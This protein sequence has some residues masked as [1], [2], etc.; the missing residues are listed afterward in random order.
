MESERCG[1]S[2]LFPQFL[3]SQQ[4]LNVGL[5]ELHEYIGRETNIDVHV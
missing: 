3:H 4:I 5:V 1:R 2:S